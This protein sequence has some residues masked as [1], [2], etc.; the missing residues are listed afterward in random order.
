MKRIFLV[1]LLLIGIG[2]VIVFLNHKQHKSVADTGLR[3]VALGDSYTIGEGAKKNEA[4]PELLARDVTAG[5]K[6]M[7]VVANPSVTGWTSQQV[8][9]NELPIYDEAKP[10]F[11]TLQIGVNDWVQGVSREEFK[12]NLVT[13]LD[14]MQSKLPDRSHLVVVTIPDFSVSP[15]GPQYANG[16]DIA[17]G[18]EEFNDV[19]K[20]ETIA[21]NLQL[22]DVYDISQRNAADLSLFANDG[23]HPSAR[24]Y[25]I[26]EQEAILPAVKK[27]LN[28]L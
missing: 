25:S 8:I 17:K 1:A 28:L 27:T 20:A 9:D 10:D 4:W 2:G 7:T 22:A 14:H 6:L 12:R 21:R 19:I 11:A 26:W 5:G 23:L 18:I 16:R 13:I 3:Y 24:Q 15:T